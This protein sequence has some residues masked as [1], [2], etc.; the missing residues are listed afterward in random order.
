[1]LWY[2][3]QFHPFFIENDVMMTLNSN[4]VTYLWDRNESI[5][6]LIFYFKI[7]QNPLLKTLFF[8]FFYFIFFIYQ[9]RYFRAHVLFACI[10][11]SRREFSRKL[12]RVKICTNKGT[13][14][15][16]KNGLWA[17]RVW[18]PPPSSYRPS[19]THLLPILPLSL[20]PS[21]Q[22]SVD[23]LRKNGQK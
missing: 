4:N 7:S 21:N 8:S 22:Y 5:K 23:T 2:F 18:S 14:D 13:C 17:L 3:R 19:V 6:Q 10:L 1:M 11:V 15:N 9:F 16:T 12:I 20:T